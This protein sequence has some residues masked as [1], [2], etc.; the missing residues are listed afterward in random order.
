MVEGLPDSLAGWRAPAIFKEG[1]RLL[2]KYFRILHP[3]ILAFFLPAALIQLLE[4]LGLAWVISHHPHH[5]HH[6][7]HHHFPGHFPHHHHHHHFGFE[8]FLFS[9][10]KVSVGPAYEGYAPAPHPGPH[11]HHHILPLLIG[12]AVGILTWLLVSLAVAGISKAVAYIYSSDEED[13]SVTKSI[14]KA[15]PGAL[16]RL[17]I[18]TLW[19]L[20]I[21]AVTVFVVSLPFHLLR[22]I[23]K[24]KLN[25]RILGIVNAVLVYVALLLLGFVFLLAQEVAVLEPSNYGLA[26]LKRSARLVKAKLPTA[27]IFFLV[28]ILVAGLLSKLTKL[29]AFFPATGKLPF[30]TVYI[31][32]V[33]IALLYLLF[34]VYFLIVAL[35]L[36]FSS[37]LKSEAEDQYLP[38]QSSEDNPYTPLVVPAEE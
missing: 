3:Y 27:T 20:L 34:W 38:V 7:H 15:L 13:P 6:H 35:V 31:F 25:P 30:W 26:A 21:T 18:T 14:F 2:G 11:H 19:L 16:F 29:A 17:F 33:L 9:S 32:A 10:H 4:V 24:A 37:K 12:A 23:F 36:Y 28:N 22:L 8:G 5:H 1:G